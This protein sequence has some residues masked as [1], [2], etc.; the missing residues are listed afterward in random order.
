MRPTTSIRSVAELVTAPRKSSRLFMSTRHV[1]PTPAKK[2]F[3]CCHVSPRL[4]STGDFNVEAKP[5]GRNDPSVA[6]RTVFVAME[7]FEYFSPA[8]SP[9]RRT[10]FPHRTPNPRPQPKP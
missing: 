10:P 5:T 6:V 4:T 1:Q 9:L 7:L 3:G 2:P 8:S